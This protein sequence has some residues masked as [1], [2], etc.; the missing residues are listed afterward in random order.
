MA[1]FNL[2]DYE[3]VDSRI[4]KLYAAHPNARIFTELVTTRIN[5][6]GQIIQYVCKAEIYRDLLDPVPSATG[7][8]EE[9]LGSNP[10]NRTSALENCET[11]AIG[12]ALA[13]LGF[14]TKGAR[15]SQ[16]EMQKAERTKQAK[17]PL[18]EAVAEVSPAVEKM[19]K[20]EQL[21][22]EAYAKAKFYKLLGANADQ[23]LMSFAGAKS[24]DK[25]DWYSVSLESKESWQ[26]AVEAWR[27]KA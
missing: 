27:A 15:P 2:A 6:A 26:K 12:R 14:S 11:S 10:I 20:F 13:N 3:T 8:A 1:N 5:D 19:E 23:F 21:K 16:E 9:V 25:I 24:F 7:Y 22:K 17:K 4:H 18:S